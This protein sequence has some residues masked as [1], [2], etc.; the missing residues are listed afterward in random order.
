M[1][2]EFNNNNCLNDSNDLSF[3]DN[4]KNKVFP[5]DLMYIPNEKSFLE[6]KYENFCFNF[7]NKMDDSHEKTVYITNDLNNI[8]QKKK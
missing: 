8:F 2:S 6:E 1:N 3:D 4:N 5:N 7:T